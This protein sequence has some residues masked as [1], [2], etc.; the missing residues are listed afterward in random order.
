M[1]QWIERVL[2]STWNGE[3]LI[4]R[5]DHEVRCCDPENEMRLKDTGVTGFPDLFDV[6]DYSE[7]LVWPDE[8]NA[9]G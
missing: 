1:Q 8:G 9:D 7:S 4:H 5:N 3:I 6:V 2:G